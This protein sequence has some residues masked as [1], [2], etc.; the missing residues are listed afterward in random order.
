[1]YSIVPATLE[2][3]QGIL[4]VCSASFVMNLPPDSARRSGATFA[5]YSTETLAALLS[6]RH[7]LV[8]VNERAEVKGYA[9]YCS[10]VGYERAFGRPLG[11]F[12]LSAK[13][14]VPSFSVGYLSQV[15][16]DVEARRMG[17]YRTMTESSIQN[18]VAEG[19]GMLFTKIYEQNEHSINVHR[20]LGWEMTT[21]TGTQ[22]VVGDNRKSEKMR[23]WIFRRTLR[24]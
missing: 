24:T 22:L 23:W 9:L 15:C 20:A 17:L 3:L 4:T 16:I 8:A 1:M 14:D 10:N 2:H 6:D 19:V 5:V 11:S 12:L 13:L 7:S 18:F 21:G